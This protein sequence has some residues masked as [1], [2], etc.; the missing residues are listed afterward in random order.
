MES[1]GTKM[2]GPSPSGLSLLSL[3]MTRNVSA[4][5]LPPP[6]PLRQDKR[7]IH[8]QQ[9]RIRKIIDESPIRDKSSF[10]KPE[11]EPMK[12][13]LMNS[14]ALSLVDIKTLPDVPEVL[15]SNRVHGAPK[16]VILQEERSGP[17]EYD[18]L[19]MVSIFD[20]TA[21]D[22]SIEI[23]DEQQS[24]PKQELLSPDRYIDQQDQSPY[25][26]QSSPPSSCLLPLP[27]ESVMGTAENPELITP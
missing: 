18:H 4:V 1:H 23:N 26:D 21:T 10:F 20:K 25:Q 27:P 11:A 7:C 9:N 3:N 17:P 12:N 2:L 24:S 15:S 22:I 5:N 14:S 6:A 19:Q 13:L 8:K 16:I